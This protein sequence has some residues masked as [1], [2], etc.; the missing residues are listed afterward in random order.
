M[1]KLGKLLLSKYKEPQ[2]NYRSSII[3][4]CDRNGSLTDSYFFFALLQQIKYLMKCQ[5]VSNS[6]FCPSLSLSLSGTHA[7]MHTRIL[8]L[9]LI[10]GDDHISWIVNYQLRFL[11]LQEIL[12]QFKNKGFCLT[13]T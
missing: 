4:K 10:I 5:L 7:C 6:V 2:C 3:K 11:L 13:L 8:E 9:R 12:F 1:L